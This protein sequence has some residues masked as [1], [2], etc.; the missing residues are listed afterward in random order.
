MILNLAAII[1]LFTWLWFYLLFCCT[2]ETESVLHD[3]Q[4]RVVV[5]SLCL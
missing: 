1:P 4:S 2:L 5:V 3:F